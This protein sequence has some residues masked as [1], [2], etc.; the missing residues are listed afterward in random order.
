MRSESRLPIVVV[1]VS[2]VLG[3]VAALVS[4]LEKPL[5]HLLVR[6]R[7][8]LEA[9][10]RRI[11][12]GDAAFQRRSYREAGELYST[13]LRYV[14]TLKGSDHHPL[15]EGVPSYD[16]LEISLEARS[17]LADIGATEMEGRSEAR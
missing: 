17:R 6:E 3:V 9:I 8:S 13:T 10:N 5:S 2:S 7:P 12:E 16:Y 15:A 11:A 4:Y 14:K 1:I